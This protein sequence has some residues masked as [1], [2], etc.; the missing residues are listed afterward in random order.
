MSRIDSYDLDTI[1]W[2]ILRELQV[3]ARL[4]YAEIGRRIGMSSP[5]VQERIRKME[6]YGIIRGYRVD[7]DL[8]KAGYPIHCYVRIGT[9]GGIQEKRLE[10][11]VRDM[12]EALEC[13]HITGAD[14]YLVRVA[15][16]SIPHLEQLVGCFQDF[17]HTVTS[18]VLS[19]PVEKRIIHGFTDD[20]A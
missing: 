7:I 3:D 1:D 2:H 16:T 8:P 13:H 9:L 17:T 10:Q 19:S 11:I 14:C 4:S 6:D 20:E 18:V 5:A 15:A 12:P